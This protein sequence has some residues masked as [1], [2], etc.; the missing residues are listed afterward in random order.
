MKFVSWKTALLG[1][2]AVAAVAPFAVTVAQPAPDGA[3]LF[4]ARCKTCHDPA[5]GRAPNRTSLA[6]MRPAD[7]VDAL[8]NGVM[9]PM[10]S[11]LSQADKA[12]IARFLTEMPDAHPPAAVSPPPVAAGGRGPS[13][14]AA[15]PT[16]VDKMCDTNGPITA[17]PGDWATLGVTPDM[18]RYQANPGLKASD[19]SKLKVKW[20]YSMAGGG[21]PT[22]VGDWLFV[23]NRTGKFYA[24]DAKTGCV[25]WVAEAASR[26]TPNIVRNALSPSGWLTIIGERN[27]TVRA[28]DAQTGKTIWQ[29]ES[30]ESVPAAGI[31]GT[32]VIAGDRILV[33]LTS[34]EEGAAG[35]NTYECCKFQGALVSLDLKTGKQQWKTKVLPEPLK[36]IGKNSAGTTQYG[37]AGGAIWSAPTVDTKRGLVY[38]ATGDSY[39]V[40]P[41]KGADAIV[42]IELATGKIRWSNQVTENDN[43]IMNCDRATKP[44]NCPDPEGPDHDFGASTILFT[45]KGGKQILLAGQKSGEVYGI[46]PDKGNVIWKKKVGAGGALG[47]V[48]WGMGADPDR[49]YVTISDIALLFNQVNPSVGI[50]PTTGE[51]KPGIYALN[52]ANGAMI[53]SAPAPKAPCTLLG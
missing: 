7:I 51:P 26:T 16:G 34:G 48:E 20:A 30:L 49:L 5:T 19:V 6:V 50:G 35:S 2:A 42:A 31:T 22:V 25:H 43:F 13:Q 53:W 27:R 14:A 18:K 36:P 46:D 12:A 45:L 10:A 44:A 9:V 17:Q 15:R 1:A 3:A 24:M 11:G 40:A 33:P 29:S 21:L 28:I 47:G 41:T 32:P 8:T 39:T 4:D 37:P 23:T 38:V 52:P